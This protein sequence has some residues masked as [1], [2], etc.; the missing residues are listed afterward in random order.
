[1]SGED[2]TTVTTPLTGNPLGW[3]PIALFIYNRP[4][5]TRRMISSLQACDGFADSPIYVFADGPR[6]DQDI[7]AIRET[8]AEARRLLGDGA[9]FLEQD[10]NR[11]VE[12]SIVAGV[13]Q[14]CDQHGVAVVIE[15]DLIFS[16]YFL[17]FLNTGL[18]L[19]QDQPRVMQVCGYMYDVPEFR[20]R[21][22]AMF[23]PMTNSLGWATWKRAWDQFDPDATGWRERLRDDRDRR[24]FDLDGHFKYA[25]MLSHHMGGR[26]PAW[27]IRWYY[28]V[29]RNDGL[30][31][32]PPRTLVLHTGF[33]GTGTHDRFS[34][35]VH[36]A[37]LETNATF[38]LPTQVAEDQSA[39]FV[40]EAIGSFRPSSN[41]RKAIALARFVLR[42]LGRAI[43]DAR[44]S[45]NGRDSGLAATDR[46]NGS[47]TGGRR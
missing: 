4:E 26:A 31:L 8:R 43:V 13:T 5:H 24:R 12:R 40:F 25:Q 36:Q 37:E 11:G 7:P 1:M 9:F 14:L 17:T 19:Y 16:P 28:S 30:V 38:V 15:D 3:A 32:Y 6:Q 29:F 46:G 34:L 23:L 33:D 47:P 2:S 45:R 18:R 20:Q 42:R 22:E 27:D 10:A 39:G 21:A 35:P 41:L 44:R